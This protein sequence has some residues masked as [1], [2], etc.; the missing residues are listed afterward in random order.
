MFEGEEVQGRIEGCRRGRRRSEVE[1]VK[2]EVVVLGMRKRD[3]LTR[4]WHG[5]ALHSA[6]SLHL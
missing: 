4:H 1:L 3:D 5:M 2:I 6:A